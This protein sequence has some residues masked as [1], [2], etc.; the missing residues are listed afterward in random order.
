MSEKVEIEIEIL[1]SVADYYEFP[2]AVFFLPKEEW[3]KNQNTTRLSS[4]IKNNEKLDK[5][6]D[7]IEGE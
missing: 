4:L 5:I 2:M 3:E 7:I 1:Q 6:K